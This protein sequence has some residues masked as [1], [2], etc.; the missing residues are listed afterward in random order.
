[1]GASTS[2]ANFVKAVYALQHESERVSTNALA[3]SLGVQA[4]S[5]TDM[6]RRLTERGLLEYERYKGVRLT[7]DGEALALKVIRRHRLIEL[8]LVQELGYALHEVH[9]EAEILE[10]AVS[11]R[12]VEALAAKLGHP[13]IDPHGD[14]IPSAEGVVVER[15]LRPLTDLPT[16]I[17]ARVSRLMAENNDM[18]QHMLDRGFHL[19]AQV[20][21]IARDPFEGPITAL[22]NGEQ[23]VIGH[24]VAR[25]IWVE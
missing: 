20:Q 2:V 25:C 24:H 7:D 10:H 5:I 16:A 18:L 12:F 3:E 9:E 21:V 23:R 15:A 6:A 22:V 11:D 14:P 17:Q 1:L 4:P 8:Y 19:D 13:T